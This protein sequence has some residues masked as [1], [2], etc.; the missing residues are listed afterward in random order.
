MSR[1]YDVARTA[2]DLLVADWPADPD[3]ALPLPARR[4]VNWGAVIWDCD[5]IVVSIE[6]T[7]GHTGDVSAEQIDVQ[8]MTMAVR[9]VTLAIW[10]VRC[11]PDIDAS[12]EQIVLPTPAELEASAQVFAADTDQVLA[13]LARRQRQ[14]DFASCDGL[15]FENCLASGPEGGFAGGV[16]RLRAEIL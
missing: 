8:P 15:G 13:I 3:V 10:I 2:L 14:H 12:G 7:F 1:T 6:R 16:T 9:A 4:Y 5:Q 11:V